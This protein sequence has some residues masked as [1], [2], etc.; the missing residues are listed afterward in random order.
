MFKSFDQIIEIIIESEGGYSD[1]PADRGGKTKYGITERVAR[2][3]GY[4]G[5]MMTLLLPVAKEIYKK[6]YWD[7]IKG[8]SIIKN[9][10]KIAYILMD[11]AVNMGVYRSSKI[12]QEAL[13]LCKKKQEL[14]IDD[15]VVDGKIGT[16]TITCLDKILEY[17]HTQ[18]TEIPK[19]LLFFQMKRYNKIVS[20]NPSQKVFLKGWLNRVEKSRKILKL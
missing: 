2:E 3:N 11:I 8:D 12:F 13:N 16:K 5:N 6:E 7:K 10:A 14:H 1:H 18:N 4:K 17:D 15:L 20:K 9:N 19:L